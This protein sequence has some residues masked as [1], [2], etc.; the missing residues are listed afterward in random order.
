VWYA[1][2][3]PAN[4]GLTKRFLGRSD[5]HVSVPARRM[6]F[7]GAVDVP[8]SYRIDEFRNALRA[9]S[10]SVGSRRVSKL[11]EFWYGSTAS[12]ATTYVES[13]VC[14]NRVGPTDAGHV[15]IMQLGL[16]VPRTP[17]LTFV[18]TLFD[19]TSLNTSP[20]EDS[21]IPHDGFHLRRRGETDLVRN[22]EPAINES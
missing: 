21:A 2:A 14:H 3:M 20:P 9:V 4:V 22:S 19:G 6:R 17:Y 7:R 15:L 1:R 16:T 18:R 8:E 10:I 13:V 5:R 12:C 11:D